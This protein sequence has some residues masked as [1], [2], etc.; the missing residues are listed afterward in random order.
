MPVNRITKPVAEKRAQLV[1]AAREMLLSLGY[2][3]TS[4]SRI[5]QAAKVTPNTIYWY[6]K[7]KDELLIAVLAKLLQE[8]LEAYVLEAQRASLAEQLVWLT[9]QLRRVGGLVGTV[10]SRM[11][12]SESV[13]AWHDHFHAVFEALLADKLPTGWT[14][15]QRAA[16]IRVV[17]FTLEGLVSHGTSVEATRQTCEAL[18]TRWQ[19]KGI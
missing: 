2:E 10:H 12:E 5:A 17:T 8:D 18:V 11:R 4:M 7:D 1:S 14:V 15:E 3:A 19:A 9:G 16:E 6:F 13:K